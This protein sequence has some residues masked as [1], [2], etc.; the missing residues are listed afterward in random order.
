MFLLSL[1]VYSS[2][3]STDRF[4]KE[5]RCFCKAFL[6]ALFAASLRVSRA[7]TLLLLL[8]R[9][10]KTGVGAGR[11]VTDG[12]ERVGT[13]MA[14]MTGL[15]FGTLFFL[16]TRSATGGAG[17]A[18]EEFTDSSRDLMKLGTNPGLKRDFFSE[19]F[20]FLFMF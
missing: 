8:R 13:A 2:T 16:S 15:A 9:T 17:A 1:F 5:F 20:L 14:R 18:G 3:S 4:F 11:L 7:F 12:S 19:I 10:A 6:S